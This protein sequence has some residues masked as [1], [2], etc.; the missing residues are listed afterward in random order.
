MDQL[1]DPGAAADSAHLIRDSD[2]GH[3]LQAQHL[4]PP[5]RRLL[6]KDAPKSEHAQPRHVTR[7]QARPRNERGQQGNA[8]AP[9]DT[10]ADA[11]GTL[12][13]CTALD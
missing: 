4:P 12:A 3:D 9:A 8:S 7:A 10:G 5:E 6:C 13:R 1:A 11:G 2:H